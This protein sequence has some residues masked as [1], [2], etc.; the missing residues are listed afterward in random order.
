MGFVKYIIRRGIYMIPLIIGISIVSFLVMYAA[1]DPIQ[2]ATA[3][4]P[5]ITEAQRDFLRHYIWA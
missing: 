2:I 3:G 5:G 1:G 4:N